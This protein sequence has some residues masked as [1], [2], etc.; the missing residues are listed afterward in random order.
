MRFL[1]WFLL[2]VN[3]LHE[4]FCNLV[5][6][7]LLFGYL[8]WLLFAQS[9]ISRREDWAFYS[10]VKLGYVVI[11]LV[12]LT[13]RFERFFL[14]ICWRAI[15]TWFLRLGI[16]IFAIFLLLSSLLLLD[17]DFLTS[18]VLHIDVNL[19]LHILTVSLLGITGIWLFNLAA[20][21]TT[22]FFL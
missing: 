2:L 16:W 1:V 8:F 17:C 3:V 18:S 19:N 20:F 15:W 7:L 14:P 4:L 9:L 5:V 12:L 11:C 13:Y 22:L 6:C 10:F 21:W